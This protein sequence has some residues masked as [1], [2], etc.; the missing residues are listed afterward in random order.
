MKIN[1]KYI[2]LPR[3][4]SLDAVAATSPLDHRAGHAKCLGGLA[5]RQVDEPYHVIGALLSPRDATWRICGMA[6]LLNDRRRHGLLAATKIS[7][8]WWMCICLLL[9]LVVRDL[10]IAHI[11]NIRLQFVSTWYN[12]PFSSGSWGLTCSISL[13]DLLIL[14]D[15]FFYETIL[16]D[17]W[18][19]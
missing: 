3:R 15:L 10:F 12:S 5:H 13:W 14:K 6:V 1:I 7:G 4:P 16:K 18:G 2:Y 9:A 8:E 11:Y 19:I 17:L